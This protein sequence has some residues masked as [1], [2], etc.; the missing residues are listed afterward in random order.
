[1]LISEQKRKRLME[2]AGIEKNALIIPTGHKLFHG[3][4]EDFKISDIKTGG[5]DDVFWTT[6]SSSIAQ[7]YIPV[8]GGFI[9]TSSGQ[10]SS[11]SKS[12]VI[13]NIQKRF[14]I[15]YQDVVYRNNQ[16]QSYKEAD[17]FK[18]IVQENQEVLKKLL[19]IDKEIRINTERATE[20]DISVQERNSLIKKNSDLIAKKE[21]FEKK[22]HETNVQKEKNNYVNKELQKLGYK[23]VAKDEYGLDYR[24][25]IKIKGFEIKNA[26]YRLSGRLFIVIPK[27]DLKIFDATMGGEVE[28]DLNSLEYNNFGLIRGAEKAGYDGIKINDFAQIESEGNFGHHSIG[29]FKNALKKVEVKSIPAT[30]PEDFGEKHYKTN[31][32]DSLEY[33]QWSSHIK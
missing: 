9:H 4:G 31:D 14:G 28:G 13:I 10:I 25:K 30:H 12:E 11:P 3:T 5:Y 17:V 2:L 6:E 18:K 27:E 24:W 21:F 7:T 32:Y 15:N 22:Y 19:N 29:L 8:A 20:K 1:M 16:L 26:D 23:P 33:K